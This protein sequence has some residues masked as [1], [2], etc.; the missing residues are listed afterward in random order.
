MLNV[1]RV[2]RL[3]QGSS[4]GLFSWDS[5]QYWQAIAPGRKKHISLADQ[6]QNRTSRSTWSVGFSL[7]PACL[8]DSHSSSASGFS[9]PASFPS[10]VGPRGGMLVKNSRPQFG[11]GGTPGI[12]L[13]RDPPGFVACDWPEHWPLGMTR[14]RPFPAVAIAMGFFQVVSLPRRSERVE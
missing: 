13:S 9:S 12:L 11:N 4:P 3:V 7:P 14:V 1:A 8:D 2:G 10:V 6:R 5:G